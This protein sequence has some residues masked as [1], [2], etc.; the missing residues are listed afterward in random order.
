[1]GNL[2][3]DIRR[4]HRAMSNVGFWPNVSAHHAI[5]IFALRNMGSVA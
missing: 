2:A 4:G 3:H 1:M 5:M